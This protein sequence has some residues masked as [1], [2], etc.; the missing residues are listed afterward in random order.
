MFEAQRTG[1]HG[2]A[3]SKEP[4]RERVLVAHAPDGGARGAEI[5]DASPFDTFEQRRQEVVGFGGDDKRRVD[6]SECMI[7]RIERLPGRHSI[8]GDLSTG[9]PK[10]HPIVEYDGD[11]LPGGMEILHEPTQ[12]AA[13][14]GEKS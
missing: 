9:K 6:G 11:I 8:E 2:D 12:H 4:L 1:W 3:C 14:L 7:K 13:S 5:D 10:G